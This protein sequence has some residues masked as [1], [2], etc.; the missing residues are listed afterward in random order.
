[1]GN[2]L[3]LDALLNEQ[4]PLW[5]VCEHEG[6]CVI[7]A[8]FPYLLPE[9]YYAGRNVSRYAA[10]RDYHTVC[11]NRLKQACA[12]LQAAF[13][14]AEFRWY[15]DNSPLP[16][17]ALAQQ[18]G[19]G[20]R[21]R[22]NLLITEPFGSWIFLG[23]IVTTAPLFR[24][25]PPGG[26]PPAASLCNH[27][28]SCLRACPTGALSENGFDRERCLSRISQRKG[29]LTPDEAALLR[30]THTAWGCD[31]CQEACPH[32]RIQARPLPEFLDDPIACVAEDTPLE[33]RAFAW[34]GKAV[35]RR[36][37]RNLDA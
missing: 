7:A 20:V 6:S 22:H 1:M 17:L 37:I 35:I 13:P 33:G 25:M 26:E 10:V 8:A 19:L 31:L 3:D 5:G 34:R 24:Y 12:L 14:E 18:A 16:E 4:L 15:C 11:G 32:N 21:G 23:E 36:N 30:Q 9:S 27:C 29:E 28:G 2:R